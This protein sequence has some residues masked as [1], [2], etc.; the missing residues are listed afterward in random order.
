MSSAYPTNA[1]APSA[2]PNIPADLGTIAIPPLDPSMPLPNTLASL[3]GSVASLA[4]ALGALATTRAQDALYTGEELRSVRAGIHGLRMQFHDMLTAQA[5]A[6][7][8][9][10][11]ARPG[12]PDGNVGP[13]GVSMPGAP[14]LNWPPYGPR[15][16]G[17]SGFAHMPGGFTKL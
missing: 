16:Y 9:S 15:P 8:S 17:M 13:G 2:Y 1:F 6:R 5:V 7:D 4:G 11:G 14:A 3:H 10:A 12:D